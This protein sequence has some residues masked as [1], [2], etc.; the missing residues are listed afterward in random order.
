[1][2]TVKKSQKACPMWELH[3]IQNLNH[4]EGVSSVLQVTC[5]HKADPSPPASLC[6]FQCPI[7]GVDLTKSPQ[8]ES[9]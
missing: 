5:N 8:G 4:Q 3:N 1:M 7:P 6:I 2:Y 9:R